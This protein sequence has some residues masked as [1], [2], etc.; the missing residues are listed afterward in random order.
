MQNLT[1]YLKERQHDLRVRY[2]A[3]GHIQYHFRL[4]ELKRL[5]QNY[6]KTRSKEDTGR[7]EGGT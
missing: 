1:D 5:I 4:L 6:D 3:T 7:T 2:K